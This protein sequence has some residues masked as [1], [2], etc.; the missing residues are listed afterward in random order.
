MLNK[1]CSWFG[2]STYHWCCSE[3][4]MQ[5]SSCL[6]QSKGGTIDLSWI[7]H[8]LFMF[9][10]PGLRWIT[11]VNLER[12]EKSVACN[13]SYIIANAFCLLIH[14]GVR[15][16]EKVVGH[17]LGVVEKFIIIC[18]ITLGQDFTYHKSLKSLH[19]SLS[20][21]NTV[22]NGHNM[23]CVVVYLFKAY[24]RWIPATKIH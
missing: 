4:V 12:T 16:D 14:V 19:F 1:E 7:G 23:V 15:S 9:W 10:I 8:R 18:Q 3:T 17:F 24:S 13:W 21:W 20:Y 11:S 6:S 5:L 22:Y 2:W